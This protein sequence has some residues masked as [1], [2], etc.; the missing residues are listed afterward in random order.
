MSEILIPATARNYYLVNKNYSYNSN[1]DVIWSFQYTVSGFNSGLSQLGYTTFLTTLSSTTSYISAGQYLC[2][3]QSETQNS[4]TVLSGT[5]TSNVNPFNL[6]TIAFDS[7]GLFALSST[8]RPGLTAVTANS[9]VIRGYN[10]QLLCVLPLSSTSFSIA[11]TSTQTIRC[12]Y[13]N[14]AQTL[15]VAYRDNTTTVYTT[16]T[17]VSIPYRF[18]NT[19]N[20]DR[21]Y[22]GISYCSPIS[23]SSL[24]S[25]RLI[26]N[27]M[28]IE[29]S[30]NKT[31][32]E[33]IA[34]DILS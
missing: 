29:G 25:C 24:S 33:T 32:I 2:T 17:T 1:Y 4:V 34:V 18:I 26:L 6:V 13:S 12:I 30:R 9:L 14:G 15:E 16:L 28:H 11:P 19:S 8:T 20:V 23:S 31:A 22:A 7:T 10:S 21:V 27:N 3:K 5:T